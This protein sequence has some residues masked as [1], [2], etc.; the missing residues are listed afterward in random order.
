MIQIATVKNNEY[1][2]T[3]KINC[4]F[5][6]SKLCSAQITVIGWMYRSLTDD[7]SSMRS[8]RKNPQ[9][10]DTIVGLVSLLVGMNT[11]K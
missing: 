6:S 2:Q 11:A 4:C 1:I 9:P 10:E 7:A 3:L 8:K 5:Y